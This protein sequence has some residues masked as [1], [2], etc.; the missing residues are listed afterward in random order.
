MADAF[1]R[2][3]QKSSST[4][5]GVVFLG[6]SVYYSAQPRVYEFYDKKTADHSVWL[7]G[8]SL[9]F[10]EEL[11]WCW[12]FVLFVLF[13]WI[14]LDFIFFNPSAMIPL[15]FSGSFTRVARFGVTLFIFFLDEYWKT[16]HFLE[17]V[18]VDKERSRWVWFRH[19]AT[20]YYLETNVA[21]ILLSICCYAVVY[22]LPRRH[23]A[24]RRLIIST[25][26]ITS[27][28]KLVKV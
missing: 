4:S 14:W 27:S 25:L 8:F 13:I 16:L 7:S 3:E 2:H 22:V 20:V 18:K 10:A 11:T 9:C 17:D 23:D 6:G 26:Q 1:S 5:G 28:F 21:Y 24:Q 12:V 19:L 15:L